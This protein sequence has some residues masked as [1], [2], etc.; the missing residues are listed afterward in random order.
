MDQ[1]LLDVG[2]IKNTKVGDEVVLI[3]RQRGANIPVEKV[4]KL[5]GTIPYEIVSGITN[6]VPRVYKK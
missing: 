5:A 3:G 6:R 2:H 1:S 4:A